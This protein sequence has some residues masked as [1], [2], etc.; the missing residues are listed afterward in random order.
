MESVVQMQ[1]RRGEL[2]AEMKKLAD[3]TG[4][5]GQDLTPAQKT[6]WNELDAEVDQLAE[7]IADRLDGQR[8]AAIDAHLG[9]GYASSVHSLL[10]DQRT[11]RHLYAAVTEGGTVRME[12]RAAVLSAS[13][14]ANQITAPMQTTGREPRRIARAANLSTQRVRG[15]ED[16]AFPVFGAGDANIQTEGEPKAEFDGITAGGVS[17]QMIALW[18]DVSRQV[19]LTQTTFENR[20]RQSLASKV[21]RRE[22]VLLT[23]TVLAT[24]G[25]Q[26]LD[27]ATADP[28]AVLQAA[29]MVASSDVAAEPNLAL[30]N[31]ADL[32]ALIGVDVGSGGRSSAPLET[33]LPT[34]HGLELYPTSAIGAGEIL[35]GAWNVA[36]RYI[37]GLPPTFLVDGVSQ[38][39][40]NLVTVLLEEAVNIAVDQP[41]GF[42]HLRPDPG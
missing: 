6:R 2:V 19:M 38:I 29:A 31:P 23:T 8:Q 25:I 22:D 20:L 11:L 41:E 40:N 42:V 21:A 24:T 26:T 4:R 9:D 12:N 36:S 33:F 16:V 27:M 18:T 37:V 34:V 15:M 13:T 7:Q 5:R 39:K 1:Q 10:P 17:P 32:S 28:D 14:G 35:V 3:G 30:V